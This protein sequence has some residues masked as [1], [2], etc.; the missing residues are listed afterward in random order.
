MTAYGKQIVVLAGEP[1]SAPRDPAELSLVY[2]LDTAKI[3]YPN[4]QQI[5]QTPSGERVPGNRRPSTERTAPPQVRGPM[6]REGPPP[7]NDGLRPKFSGSRESLNSRDGPPVFVGRGQDVSILTGPATQG[8][9]PQGPPGG[10]GSPQGPPGPGPKVPRAAA[11]QSPGPPPQQ[12][13]PQPRL[14]G[15]IPQA[16]GFAPQAPG[17]AGSRSRTPTRDNR[18][19]R[20]PLDTDGA[21]SYETQNVSPISPDAA[22]H[23][24]Q[25]RSI[26]PVMNGEHTPQQQP[27][28]SQGPNLAHAIPDMEDP[29]RSMNGAIRSRSRQTANQDP[30]EDSRSYPQ[31]SRQQP[32]DTSPYEDRMDDVPS[33]L[34]RYEGPTEEELRQHQQLEELASQQEALIA[35]LESARSRNAWYESELALARGAGYQ[36]RA[37]EM[38]A[39]DEKGAQVFNDDDRPLVE[40]LIA[41]R[42]QLAEVQESVDARVNAAAQEV[43][44]VE[45]Q[46]DVAIRE[47]A[48][49]KAKLAALGG[50][51]AGT[52]QSE[53]MSRDLDSEERSND[54]GRKLAMALATQS[55]LRQQIQAM[56]AEIESERHARELAEGTADAAH[57]R[58]TEL[59]QAYNPGEVEELRSRLHEIS[60]TARDEAAHKSEA[61]S[62]AQLLEVDKNALSNRLDE[63]LEKA[64]KH[65]TTFAALRIAVTT[66][67][68]KTSHLE[69]K[70]EEEKGQRETLEQK[71]LQ[72]RAEHEERTAELDINTRKLRD[73]EELAENHANE[74]RTHRAAMLAGLETLSNRSAD[75]RSDPCADERVSTLKEQVENAHALMR[76]IQAEAD[77][78]ADKLRSAEERI[79]GLE[80]Y[81]EQTSRESLS[82]RK[83]LQDTV[84]EL[85][86]LQIKH[87][88]VLQELDSH[89]RDKSALTVQHNALKELLDER[90]PSPGS[91]FDTPDPSRVKELEQQLE[92][93]LRAHQETKS[94]AEARAQEADQGY[95]EKLEQLEADYQS[96]VHYVKGTE[97]MLKR[98][99]DEL[100]K[101]KKQNE[102]L[103][104]DL[105]TAERSRSERSLDQ[106]AAADWEAERQQL[107]AEIGEIQ[108]SVKETV[109]QLE[110]QLEEVRGELYETQQQRDYFR[111][112]HD[113][114]QQQ[115][116]Q[117]TH[118]ARTE[119]EQL[120]NENSMLES[121]A[122]DAE[123]KVTL[124]LDQVGTSVTNYRRQSQN[125]TNG[126]SRNQSSSS[127]IATPRGGGALH[128]QSNSTSTDSTFD[129]G[130]RAGGVGTATNDRNSV[131][132][133]SLASELETLRT[134]WEGTHRNYRMSNQFDFERTPTS[135]TSLGPSE[136]ALS[137]S[138][139]NWRKRLEQEEREKEK[140]RR[141]GASSS[142]AALNLGG[143]PSF[144][145][146]GKGPSDEDSSSERGSSPVVGQAQGRG[147]RPML[148]SNESEVS[149]LTRGM[150]G[151]LGRDDSDEEEDTIARG[152]GRDG[153]RAGGM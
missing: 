141:D 85:Q 110:R 9:L 95:R 135:A 106:E 44:E 25:N 4:D 20:P 136:A 93:S 59:E 40:A 128:S 148:N 57:K 132:L 117:T 98:M 38:S 122:M 109:S 118:Q 18:P 80:A 100:T 142:G 3:R 43:S 68:E 153:N 16:P 123:Q 61:H 149:G 87:N 150:P 121:R 72:L 124:L 36:Q 131:A 107:H 151:A 74:A 56:T 92:D 116:T 126:H 23:V 41:M 32:R 22:R 120:K 113:E 67:T 1:S 6:P 47:A 104:K 37:S 30:Y 54:I 33:K 115:L 84:G 34:Q 78:A 144:G 45:Q 75:T 31:P 46:R 42:K 60:R 82:A 52:P 86:A 138:L 89:Q 11:V 133:D 65:N 53:G 96:A 35:E 145:G 112:G 103:R 152:P 69:R 8:S 15:V 55:E 73:A 27:P 129:M 62:K 29:Q 39:L 24:P 5:Q 10:G 49:A 97:K 111:Q 119:L 91:R 83:Q 105:D 76:Q 90:G 58:A 94:R 28:Q 48:Y 139:A 137:D 12:Q 64:Q 125:M 81:Q 101:Y 147:M 127:T 50:S 7:N 99:K 146:R 71:L 21:N 66:S 114:A 14:N 134:H 26:S 19:Y 63:A 108:Q 17:S 51:T 88:G 143:G 70:L 77:A 140:G 79:A 130:S 2:V 102:E 13:P